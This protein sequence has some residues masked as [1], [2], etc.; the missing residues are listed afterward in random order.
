VTT[1]LALVFGGALLG[2]VAGYVVGASLVVGT[3]SPEGATGAFA[4]AILG[5]P[6]GAVA[7]P[8]FVWW[9]GRRRR[10]RDGAR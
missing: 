9:R 2:V 10:R 1:F 4:G 7:L 6:V 5:A 8:A 3:Q